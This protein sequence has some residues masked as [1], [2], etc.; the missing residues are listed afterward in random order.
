MA[1]SIELDLQKLY[2]QDA[3]RAFT[4]CSFRG[5]ERESGNERE[6]K[7]MF[8]LSPSKIAYKFQL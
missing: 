7:A 2:K 5:F 8:F 3:Q 1:C 6:C 4:P